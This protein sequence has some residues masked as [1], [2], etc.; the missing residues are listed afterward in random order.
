MSDLEWALAKL[1]SA[2]TG[3]TAELVSAV[4][5]ADLRSV[6]LSSEASAALARVPNLLDGLQ[7][8]ATDTEASSAPSVSEEQALV[9][10][11][12]AVA[13]QH[14]FV[15]ANWTGPNLD[16]GPGDVIAAVRGSDVGDAEAANTAA[17]AGALPYLTLL[18]EPAY[19]LAAHP[20]LFLLSVRV[21]AFLKASATLTTL[22]WWLLRSHL[23]HL[24]LLDEPVALAEDTIS[25]VIALVD[26]APDADTA[27][28][29]QLELGL[30]H[31]RLG[32][33]RAANQAF[34]AA[35]RASGL[36]FELTGA[37]GKR[38]K[39]Q[40]TDY[41][42]LVLLAE[43]RAREGDAVAVKQ[44]VPQTL[45]LN[46]DTLLEETEFTKVTS[47]G[48]GALSHL[49]PSNQPPLHPL[50]QALLLS[51]CL[52]Q[53]N[54]S[55]E[56]GLTNQQM[57]PFL[58]R[59]LAHPRNWSVHTTALLLRSRLEA[60]RSRTVERSTLQLAALI[61]Q[62]PTA[63]SAPAERL[64]YFHQLPL[65]SKWEMER[66]LAKR[67]LSLGVIRSA[68]EIFTRLEMWED[69]VTAMQRMEMDAEAERLVHD[70]LEGRKIESD[71]VVQLGKSSLSDARRQKIS[72]VR[73]AKLWCVLGDLALNSDEGIKNPEMGRKAAIVKYE[74]AWEV[75]GES[76][77]RC[78]R[79][80]GAM[81]TSAQMYLPAIESFKKALAINP[82]YAHS[83]FTLGVCYMRLGR[84]REARD[85][86][87]RQV[88]VNPDDSEGWNNLAAVYLRMNEEGLAEGEQP[89][90]VSYE[91]KQLAWHALKSGLRTS[92]DNWRMWQNY[93]V[94]SVDVGEL[95]EAVRAMTRVVE[96]MGTKD[97]LVAVNPAVL[98]KLVDAVSRDNWN[99]GN[100]PEDGRPPPTSNEGWGLLPLVDRLFDQTIFP[101]INDDP[102]VWR[103]HARLLRWKED[104]AGA[105]EDYVRAY[106]ADVVTDERV[107]RDRTRWREAVREVEDLVATFQLLGPR[108]PKVEGKKGGDWRFQARGIVRTFMGRSKDA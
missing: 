77:S 106:R 63:D 97:P 83:W 54:D 46:D 20:A 72:S 100:G 6:L 3:W 5:N 38:T 75:S 24:A 37:M 89:A 43:S 12:A 19:H 2:G 52:S 62:M 44:D 59:V 74:K 21:L 26:A 18:G 86:F 31:N 48:S 64:L 25:A 7:E 84:W 22:P 4:K 67:Y 10:L 14:A 47:T 93:M 87:K 95:S 53:R 49:D 60:N 58:A 35:A 13:L 8:G 23:V 92:Y 101:R 68:L 65:P 56:H 33:D 57:M 71:I 70:L 16:F 30:L 50:D 81:Y 108:V 28:A 36:E 69:A 78:M 11:T 82:L 34:L 102:R 1:K 45:A 9:L 85:S 41:S 103:A 94:V 104:W 42:Q 73:A 39:F 79:S 98:D 76:N 40:V 90:P 61:D 96:V 27:A 107:E 29:L 66:E 80:L 32:Q 17:N 15:Q 55:P 91:T 105:L 88:G 51:L 99:A